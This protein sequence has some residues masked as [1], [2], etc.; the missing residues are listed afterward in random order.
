M[1]CWR[2]LSDKKSERVSMKR[3]TEGVQSV[4][5]LSVREVSECREWNSNEEK[6]GTRRRERKQRRRSQTEQQNR[7]RSIL[8]LP[9]P[10]SDPSPFSVSC[11]PATKGDRDGIR[12]GWTGRS[13]LL[14]EV[15]QRWSAMY[16][17]DLLAAMSLTPY[18]CC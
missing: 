10:R 2:G 6:E 11:I 16:H 9:L 5:E 12:A 14:C 13:E 4:Y 17:A 7:S 3:K 8:S 15:E 1:C 18:T